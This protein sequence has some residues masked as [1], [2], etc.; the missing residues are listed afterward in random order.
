MSTWVLILTLVAA[1]SSGGS[2][3]TPVPGFIDKPS[4]KAAGDAWVNSSPQG[5]GF[6]GTPY[7]KVS[8]VCVEQKR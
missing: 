2:A 3:V 1:G 4:C 8:F 5:F 6:A 7:Q